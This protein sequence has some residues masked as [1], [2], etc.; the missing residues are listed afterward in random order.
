MGNV[1]P[2]S[3]KSKESYLGLYFFY[4]FMLGLL[5]HL[6]SIPN[7]FSVYTDDTW[8]LFAVLLWISYFI[9]SPIMAYVHYRDAN[10]LRLGTYLVVFTTGLWSMV[11][12][13]LYGIQALVDQPFYQ[14]V[15]TNLLWGQLLLILF[16]WVKWIPVRTRKLV[17]RGVTV[18]LGAFFLFHVPG[19]TGL[20]RDAGLYAFLFKDAAQSLVWPGFALFFSGLWTRFIMG[21][22]IDLDI[23]PGERAHAIAE[24]KVREEAEG[25]QISEE[26]LSSERYLYYGELDYPHEDGVIDYREKGSKKFEEVYF[27]YVEAGVRYFTRIY[28]EEEDYFQDDEEEMI[29][30]K[31]NG[32]WYCQTAGHEPE[33][34]LLPDWYAEEEWHQFEID[35]R[36][37][38]KRAI[39]NGCPVP[40]FVEIPSD[41]DESQVLR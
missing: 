4:Q 7:I 31:E 26:M 17:A 8:R 35:K 37:Y 19:I 34:V 3:D 24:K 11:A 2:S 16:S 33:P 38:L 6:Y 28:S 29:L 41:I 23:T 13:N 30:Y 39:K 32:Q 40:F 10:N 15:Y 14:G 9:V 1:I 21:T 12:I 20:W 27:L 5:V 22:G 25:R 36:E 18:V